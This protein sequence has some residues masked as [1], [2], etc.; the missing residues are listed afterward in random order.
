MTQPEY[1]IEI[2]SLLQL[3]QK[4][5][6]TFLGVSRSHYSMF[7]LGKRK[8]PV[9]AMQKVIVLINNTKEGSMTSKQSLDI[10]IFKKDWNHQLL[11]TLTRENEYQLLL[12]EKKIARAMKTQDLASKRLSISI[13]VS[14]KLQTPYR[15]NRK[16]HLA[17]GKPA[18]PKLYKEVLQLEIRKKVLEFEKELL[19]SYLLQF[20]NI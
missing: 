15:I 3:N 11:V 18:I 14:S 5:M 6:A 12:I 20:S 17:V 16:L 8:L 10:E 4:D 13:N 9:N 7:E 1:I 2:R 19:A